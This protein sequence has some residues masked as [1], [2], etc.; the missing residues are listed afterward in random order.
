MADFE[1]ILLSNT[2][3]HQFYL[4]KAKDIVSLGTLLFTYSQFQA[5]AN[6]V[7]PKGVRIY[8]KKATGQVT[9]VYKLADGV[10]KLI[11]LPIHVDRTKTKKGRIYSIIKNLNILSYDVAN[12]KY[13]FTNRW[14]AGT[15][16]SLTLTDGDMFSV[17]LNNDFPYVLTDINI[18]I[19]SFET[20]GVIQVG[21][22]AWD[23]ESTNYSLSFVNT[24]LIWNSADIN[25]TS[26]GV[27]TIPVPNLLIEYDHIFISLLKKSGTFSSIQFTS[28]LLPLFFSS[29]LANYHAL[30]CKHTGLSSFPT[31]LSGGSAVT[32]AYVMIGGSIKIDY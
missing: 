7:Y 30:A 14:Q 2:S 1:D 27:V 13:T 32:A 16:N 21:I 31:N 6:V 29:N 20:A 24:S 26:A 17:S 12:D 9:G 28:G 22:Y 19:A 8:Y 25:I 15:T 18:G 5:N 11:D 4:G 3:G 10:N 23:N